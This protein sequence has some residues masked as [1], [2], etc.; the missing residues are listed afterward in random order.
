MSF[1]IKST[2]FISNDSP[3]HK[4]ISAIE[5]SK[6][7]N[8][9]LPQDNDTLIKGA[10]IATIHSLEAVSSSPT[11]TQAARG[12]GGAVL[13][14]L[15]TR[16]IPSGTKRMDVVST[17][18][19]IATLTFTSVGEWAKAML[20]IH[21]VGSLLGDADK[22]VEC[23]EKDWKDKAGS[24]VEADISYV[25][26]YLVGTI[27]G[28]SPEA[29]PDASP[30]AS[31]PK[32]KRKTSETPHSNEHFDLQSLKV[33]DRVTVPTVT[34]DP[35]DPF[36]SIAAAVAPK[37]AKVSEA[38]AH[39]AV[40]EALEKQVG[41]ALESI[42][43]AVRT[44]ARNATVAS[45]AK[46]SIDED[47]V[48]DIV[49]KTAAEASGA[50]IA[51]I[52]QKSG[53]SVLVKVLDKAADAMSTLVS[54][55]TA[56]PI[57]LEIPAKDPYYIWDEK[58]RKVCDVIYKASSSSP[59]QSMLVG[60]TGSGKTDM[61]QQFAAEYGMPFVKFDCANNRE[62]RDWFGVKG[63]AGGATYFR[64]SK[65]WTAVEAGGCVILLDEFNR[66]PDHVRNP[67]MPLFDHTK[68]SYVEDVGEILSVGPGTI[69][70][71][72]L[73][74][75]FEYSGTFTTDRAMQSRFTRRIEIPYLD[76]NREIEVLTRKTALSGDVAKR[77]VEAA[78]T[79]REK[80]MSVSGGGLSSPISTRQLISAAQDMVIGGTGTL[81]YTIFNH[82]SADGG[83]NSERAQV[84]KTFELK[85]FKL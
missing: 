23:L 58:L 47:K 74:E 54:V 75:G 45:A 50:T 83:E 63:A 24:G 16:F 64:K 49:A 81:A 31:A 53:A 20:Y 1:D 10:T 72:T 85:G 73:N 77:L 69:F 38:I 62:P 67:L 29:K 4:L 14:N 71:A 34:T 22:L 21:Y 33:P 15:C 55:P 11:I 9:P 78:T 52:V 76:N 79:I 37:T 35:T 13:T 6:S 7:G 59:Q 28:G 48:R 84:I 3:I 82:Y 44:L 65:F 56:A 36:S 42:H 51:D 18:K 40:A 60:P 5:I 8:S 27:S 41:P 19:L 46:P 30:D 26:G 70:F 39:N 43:T 25:S 80:S 12:I 2:K 68:R 32:R 61:A 17:A 57:K 66:A